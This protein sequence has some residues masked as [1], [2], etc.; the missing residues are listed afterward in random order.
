M[1]AFS[2]LLATFIDESG[3]LK[4]PVEDVEHVLP[5]MLVNLPVDLEALDERTL[6]AFAKAAESA[7]VTDASDPA[8]IRS[9]FDAYYR[10]YP[11]SPQVVTALTEAW[12]RVN[13]GEG[14]A[15]FSGFLGEHQAT[16]VLGGGVRPAGTVPAALGRLAHLASKKRS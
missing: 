5:W 9:A 6:V 11:P 1:D 16:G 4:Y 10:A 3:A 14:P 13:E 7:G 12:R 8:E 2:T 15:A